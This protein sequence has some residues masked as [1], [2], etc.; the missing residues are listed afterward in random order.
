MDWVTTMRQSRPRTDSRRCDCL[1]EALV[2]GIL[3]EVGRIEPDG[4]WTSDEVLLEVST[5]AY[6][7]IAARFVEP[8]LDSLFDLAGWVLVSQAPC[9]CVVVN[10]QSDLDVGCVRGACRLLQPGVRISIVNSDQLWKHHVV[11]FA[12]VL[13]RECPCVGACHTQ[14][15]REVVPPA[16]DQLYEYVQIE[17]EGT[18]MLVDVAPSQR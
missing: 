7:K 10:Q 5:N 14:C 17:R 2:R 15:T 6:G 18:R 11:T 8:R 9:V 12:Q 4:V 3:V 13:R 16:A 1:Q